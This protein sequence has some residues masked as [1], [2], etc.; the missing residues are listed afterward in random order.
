MLFQAAQDE[1]ARSRKGDLIRPLYESYCFSNIP[2]AVHWLAGGT[3]AANPLAPILASADLGPS[4]A[5]KVVL[6]LIDGLGWDHWLAYAVQRDPFRRINDAGI[7]AP[8]TTIFPSTTAAALTTINSGLTPRQ[9]GLPEWFVYFDEINRIAATLPFTAMGKKGPDQLLD[10]GVDPS[11]L[12]NGEPIYPRLESEGIKTFTFIN[13]NYARSTYS[14]I[15]H[16]GSTT[17]PVIDATDLMV[18]LRTAITETEGPAY[19]YVYWDAVDAIAHAEGPHSPQFIAEIETF[20]AALQ[21]GLVDPIDRRAAEDTILLVSA[22]HG[23]IRVDPAETI[24]LNQYEQLGGSF[25]R[26]ANGAAILPWGS[27]RDVY[28]AIEPDKVGAVRDFLTTQLDGRARVMTS[29]DALAAN[30][31]GRGDMH[32]KLRQRIGDLIVLPRDRHMV[33]YEHSAGQRL[34]LNGMH[35]GLSEAEMIIPFAAARLSALQ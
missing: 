20:A 3:P 18:N 34:T 7:V 9:H 30:M 28:L 19:F 2:A 11:L 13:D 21:V 6:L 12:F 22:D 24:Y 32:P 35:G 8:L 1:I 15:V 27:P 33:W 5:N 31:F 4:R 25:R 14:S 16:R 23:H 17:V 26:D 29:A 10:E